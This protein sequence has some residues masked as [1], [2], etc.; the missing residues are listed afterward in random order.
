VKV[1]YVF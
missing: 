1:W